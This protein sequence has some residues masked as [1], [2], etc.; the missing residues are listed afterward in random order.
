MVNRP[1]A[2]HIAPVIAVTDLDRARE[3]YEHRLG[4]D[5]AETP[6]GWAASADHGTVLNLLSGVPSAGSADWPVATFRVDDVH[7]TVRA[8]R[9][10]GVP[11]LGPDDLPFTLD[12]DG[13]SSQ[14][15]E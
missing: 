1:T 5:G 11:F 6:G 14:Q 13:V 12:D 2:M 4:L 3:F 9:S 15:Q 8:L 10:R 7:A